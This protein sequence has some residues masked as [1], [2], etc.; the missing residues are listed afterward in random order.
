MDTWIVS[1]TQTLLDFVK[2]EMDGNIKHNSEKMEII[3]YVDFLAYRLYTVVPRLVKY[4]DMLT[5]WYVKLNKKRF[6]VKIFISFCCLHSHAIHSKYNEFFIA[7]L[8]GEI[9]IHFFLKFI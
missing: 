8:E 3:I 6:K 7:F 9:I 1:Y 5:N 2:Q 4:I